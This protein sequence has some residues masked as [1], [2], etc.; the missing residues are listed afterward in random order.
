M[1]SY[2]IS[3][4]TPSSSS[5]ANKVITSE[6]RVRLSRDVDL[7]VGAVEDWLVVV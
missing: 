6:L 2:V 1:N 5:V 3:E 4:F 7:V